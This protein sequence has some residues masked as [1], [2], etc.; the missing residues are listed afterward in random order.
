M[1]IRQFEF[2][3][4]AWPVLNQ[5]C[6]KSIK[7]F[8]SFVLKRTSL[9]FTPEPSELVVALCS[10]G[11]SKVLVKASIYLINE[12][13]KFEIEFSFEPTFSS[14]VWTLSLLRN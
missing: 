4:P 6:N 2:H 9:L 13:F 7:Y 14:R 3:S 1:E 12:Y 8:F 5:H 11:D 10:F